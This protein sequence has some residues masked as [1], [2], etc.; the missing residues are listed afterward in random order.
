MKTEASQ[1]PKQP[2]KK[3]KRSNIVSLSVHKN[4]LEKRIRQDKKEC[5]KDYFASVQSVVPSPTGFAIVAW[6][7]T[8]EDGLKASAFIVDSLNDLEL[9]PE[10]VKMILNREINK[11][12]TDNEIEL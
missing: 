8:S 7:S 5:F 4:T 11:F 6:D 12:I 2:E 1:E 3:R 10:K 9:F